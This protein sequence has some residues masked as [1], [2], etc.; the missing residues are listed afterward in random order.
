MA[1]RVSLH[2]S[3]NS[4]AGAEGREQF[5]EWQLGFPCTRPLTGS[6]RRGLRFT[7]RDG[8]M[9]LSVEPALT[10]S[11]RR[12]SRFT[13]LG[14]EKRVGRFSNW[15]SSADPPVRGISSKMRGKSFGR[16]T[17]NVRGMGKISDC[18]L[19]GVFR[20][21]IPVGIG[22]PASPSFLQPVRRHPGF[23][24]ALEPHL[25]HPDPVRQLRRGRSRG[26]ADRRARP[27]PFTNR[28]LESL[29]TR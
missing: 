16:N 23:H 3:L 25:V 8:D 11:A 12:G 5:A 7:A 18:S 20:L 10:G 26:L 27:T 19:H 9:L 21:P 29:G 24:Q 2:P 15:K 14:R 22:L 4:P 6:A 13:D 28:L 1:T 17:P